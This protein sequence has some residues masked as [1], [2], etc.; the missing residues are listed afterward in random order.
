LQV[1]PSPSLNVAKGVNYSQYHEQLDQLKQKIVESE[2][3]MDE[4]NKSIDCK[5]ISKLVFI[6]FIL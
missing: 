2:K 5:F 1:V 3:K 6:S 4:W